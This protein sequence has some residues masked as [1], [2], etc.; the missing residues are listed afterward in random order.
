M[1]DLTSE[2]RAARQVR[3]QARTGESCSGTST[4]ALS[5]PGEE[6]WRADPHRDRMLPRFAE[7]RNTASMP[8]A[9]CP[10]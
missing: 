7:K 1:P 5:R 4:L 6:K 3:R 8:E 2:E 10:R 9:A